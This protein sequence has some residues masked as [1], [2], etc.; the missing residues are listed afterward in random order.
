M[1]A[2]NQLVPTTPVGVPVLVSG[3]SR[4]E[5]LRVLNLD[6]RKPETMALILTRERY[7]LDPI[8][9]HALL[10]QGTL[11]VTRDGLMH[12]AHVSGKFDG[13]EV[14]QLG[15]TPTHYIAK[16]TVWRKDMTRPFVFQGRFPKSKP[17]AK[18]FG[19]EMAEKVAECRALRRAFDISLCS[20]EETWENEDPAPL[21]QSPQRPAVHAAHPRRIVAPSAPA[22]EPTEDLLAAGKAFIDAAGKIGYQFVDKAD[23]FGWLNLCLGLEW[24]AEI[25]YTVAQ[26]KEATGKLP[27]LLGKWLAEQKP[28]GHLPEAADEEGVFLPEAPAAPVQE[29]LESADEELTDPFDEILEA[30]AVLPKKKDSR[31]SGDGKV[32]L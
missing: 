5:I 24:D 7:G 3:P 15:E 25:A 6:Q 23:R 8:L 12:V 32:M 21:M 2:N 29:P 1:S 30:T 13:L 16:A 4:D 18:E 31:M 19:P 17:M 27:D 22:Q 10:I 9:K 26:I 28:I 14:E 11:Y 20:R